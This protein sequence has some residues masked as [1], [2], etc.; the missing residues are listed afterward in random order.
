[1]D[2]KKVIEKLAGIVAKQQKIIEKLAQ[3][4]QLPGSGDPVLSGG[5]D[6]APPAHPTAP[7]NFQPNAPNLRDAEIILAAL[8]PVIKPTIAKL[9]VHD[10]DILVRFHPNKDSDQ[11]FNTVIQTVHNLQAANKLSGHTY[12]VKQVA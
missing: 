11:A 12:Q 8:P 2:S 3:A 10:N 6:P 1:M 9:E 7:Q 5:K 4:V